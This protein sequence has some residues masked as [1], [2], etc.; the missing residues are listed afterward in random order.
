MQ[1]SQSI[2]IISWEFLSSKFLSPE[3]RLKFLVSRMKTSKIKF[4]M[5]KSSVFKPLWLMLV[6][7]FFALIR[8]VLYGFAFLFLLLFFSFLVGGS[9]SLKKSWFCDFS[10]KFFG[11]WIGKTISVLPTA[12]LILILL[13]FSILNKIIQLR[14]HIKSF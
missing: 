9:L 3:Y 2:Y 7:R 5:W 13:L 12:H 14:I 4:L 6:R 11:F 8:V 1:S 10:T